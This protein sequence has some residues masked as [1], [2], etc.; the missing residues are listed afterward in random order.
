MIFEFRIP[1]NIN[2]NGI[3]S[4]SAKDARVDELWLAFHE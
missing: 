2:M 1:K 3:V 4:D